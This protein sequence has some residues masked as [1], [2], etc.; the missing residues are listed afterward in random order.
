MLSNIVAFLLGCNQYSLTCNCM[1]S[2]YNQCNLTCNCMNFLLQH[3]VFGLILHFIVC[4]TSVINEYDINPS[5]F[6]CQEHS[7]VC[8]VNK[9]S[10]GNPAVA[11]T[12]IFCGNIYNGKAY[13]FHSLPK[14]GN[15]WVKAEGR[16]KKKPIQCYSKEKVFN[17]VTNEWIYRDVPPSG[18]FCFFPSSWTINQTVAN[19]RSVYFYCKDKI[20]SKGRICG[21]NYQGKGF[22]IIIFLKGRT[23]AS[24]FATL[25][26]EYTKCRVNCDLRGLSFKDEKKEDLQGFHDFLA[27]IM[28]WN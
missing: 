6:K 7:S 25:K 15:L 2:A 5:K 3:V 9:W 12:H 27:A 4:T 28:N 21:R 16:V 24:S 13:G 26:N 18:H 23:I 20:D 11:L 19:I 8:G 1:N 17:A 22:D 14:S 10:S